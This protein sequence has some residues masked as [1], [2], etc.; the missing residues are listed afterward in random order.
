MEIP[1]LVVSVTQAK[2]EDG[3]YELSFFGE[4][5]LTV[6]EI[7]QQAGLLHSQIRVS[8]VGGL[9][10]AGFDPFRCPPPPLHLCI[11]FDR[12]PTDTLLERLR[13]DFS[14]A[15]PNPNRR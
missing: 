7:C 14:E 6:A 12:D 5:G 2:L 13:G 9:R 15:V 11:R 10:A 1:T 3:A 8:T 4:N